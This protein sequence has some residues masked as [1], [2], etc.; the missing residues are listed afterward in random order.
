MDE[1]EQIYFRPI[2]VKTFTS[3]LGFITSKRVAEFKRDDF[4]KAPLNSFVQIGNDLIYVTY[5]GQ[6]HTCMYVMKKIT[7]RMNECPLLVKIN[8][9]YG[10]KQAKRF[11]P[12]LQEESVKST[13]NG[14]KSQSTEALFHN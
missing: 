4:N 8:V 3:K 11:K 1:L 7:S 9:A 13:S 2:S 5:R 12:N 14:A 6:I 10:Q